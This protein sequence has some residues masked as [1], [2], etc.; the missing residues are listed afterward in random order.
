MS[1]LEGKRE[2]GG[3]RIELT[4]GKH[5]IRHKSHNNFIDGIFKN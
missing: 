2:K 4:A 3:K 5:T 1:S